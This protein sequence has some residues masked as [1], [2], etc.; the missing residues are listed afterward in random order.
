LNV[1][2]RFSP[3]L[4]TERAEL[5]RMDFLPRDLAW[6]PARRKSHREINRT[7]THYP[8][9]YWSSCT[10]RPFFHFL[11][12]IDAVLAR[13]FPTARP[14]ILLAPPSAAV[15]VIKMKLPGKGQAHPPA[16]SCD[17]IQ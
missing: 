2:A 16:P 15:G 8:A 7:Q 1:R 4:A 13:E 6:E 9:L 12:F 17:K 10:S 14:G 3:L 5:V 11:S